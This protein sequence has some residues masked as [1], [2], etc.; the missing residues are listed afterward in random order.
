MPGARE[1]GF[2][3]VE[4][5]AALAVAAIAAA[6]LM[7]SLASANGRSAEADLRMSALR[8]AEVLLAE[9]VSAA[10]PATLAPRGA[11]SSTRLSWTRAFEDAGTIYPGLQRVTV[12]VN[13]T[14]ISRKGATRLEAYRV[15]PRR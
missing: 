4:A 3:L 7:T 9:G 15:T 2:V 10:D 5:I 14:A 8:Q 6:A 12:E 11:V 1:D 13:W